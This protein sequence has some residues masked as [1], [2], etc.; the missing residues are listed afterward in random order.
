MAEVVGAKK[1]EI[2]IMNSLSTNMH[3]MLVPFYQP[4]T[5]RYK[6]I[7]EAGAFPSDRYGVRSHLF[8]HNLTP[9][10]ALIEI[11]P[12]DGESTLRTEDIIKVCICYL[13]FSAHLLTLVVSF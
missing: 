12:R 7:V 13:F 8:L 1:D 5:D 4:T 11:K 9:E 6:I 10:Q 3:L 2:A